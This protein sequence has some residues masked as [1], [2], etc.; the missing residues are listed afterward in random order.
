MRLF[1]NLIE[2]RFETEQRMK[3]V[4]QIGGQSLSLEG[5]KFEW[6]KSTRAFGRCNY[7]RKVIMMSKP[8]CTANLTN[9]DKIIDTILHEIAHGLAWLRWGRI[10]ANHGPYW[11]QVAIQIGSSGKRCWSTENTIAAPGK[12]TLTCSTCGHTHQMQKRPKR[13]HSCGRCCPGRFNRTFLMTIV[14]NK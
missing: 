6:I 9:G 14:K 3:V 7:T 4:H 10:A 5:W 2:V 11:K 12:Y 13:E 8:L 1:N